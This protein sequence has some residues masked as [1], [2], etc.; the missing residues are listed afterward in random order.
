MTVPY[1]TEH[2]RRHRKRIREQGKTEILLTLPVEVVEM[3][4]RLRASQGVRSRGD[5]V[6]FLTRQVTEAGNELKQ[7]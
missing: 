3:L 6:S 1:S 4:D 7:A 2:V 5:V